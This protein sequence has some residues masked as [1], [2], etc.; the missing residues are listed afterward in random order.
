MTRTAL[1]PDLFAATHPERDRVARMLHTTAEILGAAFTDVRL[2]GYLL[3]LADVPVDA[4]AAGLRYA[5]RHLG[6]Y[7]MPKPVE[8]RRAVDQALHAQQL[9]Q[10][11]TAH[12]AEDEDPRVS[13][14]CRDCEDLGLVYVQRAT[15]V[16]VAVSQVTGSHALWAVRPC[17]CVPRNPVIQRRYAKATR[18]SEE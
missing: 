8:L 9:A 15:G 12:V 18:Y 10:G 16:H 3:A 1:S 17:P 14:A 11:L 7:G 4:L 2:E 6:Q 13:V 5:V